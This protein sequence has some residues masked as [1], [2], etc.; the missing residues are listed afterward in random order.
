VSSFFRLRRQKIEKSPARYWVIVLY[1]FTS[2][3]QYFL[4]ITPSELLKRIAAHHGRQEVYS[5]YFC[6]LGEDK[7]WELRGPRAEM[8]AAIA[9]GSIVQSRDFS[10]FLDDWSK[11]H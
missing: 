1:S 4:V 11:I 3:K 6:V 9:S 10:G 5:L 2:Q 8:K 7:C